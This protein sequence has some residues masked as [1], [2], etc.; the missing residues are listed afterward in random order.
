MQ[1]YFAALKENLLYLLEISA[2][3]SKI[4]QTIYLKIDSVLSKSQY[5]KCRADTETFGY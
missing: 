5:N 3:F 2:Q 4:K 1:Q